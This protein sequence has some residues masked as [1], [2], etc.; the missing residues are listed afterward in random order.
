VA[1]RQNA[2]VV[3]AQDWS[4]LDAVIEALMEQLRTCG[5]PDPA[6]RGGLIR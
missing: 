1:A 6:H 3:A 2:E 4:G 5:V